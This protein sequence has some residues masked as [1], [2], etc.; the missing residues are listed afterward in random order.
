MKLPTKFPNKTI[1]IV[2][3]FSLLFGFWLMF[4]TFSY[5]QGSI[6]IAS[7]AWSD[8][9]AHI[10]LIR[11]FS[12]GNNFPPQYPIFSG[13]PIKYHFL[14]YF[15]VGY[16]EKAGLRL[17]FALNLPS[18]IS[19]AL[20]M[21]I[22]YYFAK[23]IFKSKTVG[24]LALTFFLFNGSLSFL[25][26]FKIHP[27]SFHSLQDI[28]S[29]NTFPSFGPYDGKEISAFWNLNIY[30]NQRHLALSF[31]VSLLIILSVVSTFFERYKIK[32]SIFLG[33]I[34]GGFFFFHFAVFLMTIV[35]LSCLFLL[36][37]K[38]RLS[39]FIILGITFLLTLPQYFYL[40]NGGSNFK[41]SFVPGYLISNNLNIENF[42][43]YWFNNLGLH[44]ILAPL[45]FIF[46]PKI[47]KKI[48][49]AFIPI[50]I[51]GNTLQFSPE[52]AGNHKFFNYFML[53]GVMFSAYF[54]VY[55]WKHKRI[56][57]FSVPIL[58]F[59]LIF[60]GII[61]F[62]PIMNDQKITLTDYPINKD[63][64]W[65]KESTP[66]DSVFLNSSYIYDPASVAGR[67]IFLGWPYFAWSAGYNTDVRKQILSQILGSNSLDGLC[68]LL[69]EN[70]I[71]YLEIQ[72]LENRTLEVPKVSSIFSEK[73]IP[74]YINIDEEYAIYSVSEN[75]S[76]RI[77]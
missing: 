70:H 52:M 6:L 21:F 71:D 43:K 64:N 69:Q 62:F 23:T 55:L 30:T 51:I 22:I 73:F 9:A 65:I 25:E 47:S 46:A 19:F 34:L 26:F 49:L 76:F 27:L 7:K 61:D 12:L 66:P 24:V 2:I 33:L 41:L 77:N 67:K 74:L 18:A 72:N 68:K 28:I 4:H 16:L 14:F 57:K 50:L 38:Q 1:I 45:G 13:E 17:D 29:N 11:S 48:L 20:L 37:P 75:C 58:F 53:L 3:I 31:F 44:L 15:F 35:V 5:N 8:F 32:L 56:L 42:I 59:L 54:L 39:I 63:V 60:S 36:L 40:Q 10:P